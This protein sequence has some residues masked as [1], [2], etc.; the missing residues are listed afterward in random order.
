MPDRPHADLGGKRLRPED[1]ESEVF[2]AEF[3]DKREHDFLAGVL[4]IADI[5]YFAKLDK[6]ERHNGDS[7]RSHWINTLQILFYELSC[8]DPVT[9]AVGLLHDLVEDEYIGSEELFLILSE[10]DAKY[11]DQ[12]MQ[13]IWQLTKDWNYKFNSID[14]AADDPDWQLKKE[15]ASAEKDRQKRIRARD[16]FKGLYLSTDPRV[17]LVKLADRLSNLRDRRYGNLDPAQALAKKLHKL[18]ETESQLVQ[19]VL[20]RPG[21]WE[22]IQHEIKI[23]KKEIFALLRKSPELE[24]DYLRIFSELGEIRSLINGIYDQTKLQKGLRDLGIK[25]VQIPF[26]TF[27]LVA[28]QGVKVVLGQPI[29]GLEEFG[30]VIGFYESY[31]SAVVLYD[32]NKSGADAFK[33]LK[34]D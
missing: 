30:L 19:D 27:V 11:A 32:K 24:L 29:S 34:I 25:L 33:M 15:F 1:F 8:R 10:L 4:H 14:G 5:A 13:A 9:L 2:L 23:T 16:Y 6:P 20:S 3:T 26:E 31:S 7:D 22:K 12:I 21:S 18:A 17:A 28:G